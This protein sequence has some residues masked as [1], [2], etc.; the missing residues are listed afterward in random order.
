MQHALN[1][2]PV[3]VRELKALGFARVLLDVD[4]YRQG[5]LNEALPL[6]GAR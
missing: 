4:G 6:L 5:S 3:L 1:R 2:G